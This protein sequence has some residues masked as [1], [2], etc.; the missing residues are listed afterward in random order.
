ML[1]LR[2]L[3]LLASLAAMSMAVA[4][5]GAQTSYS[6]RDIGTLGGTY[7]APYGVNNAGTVVGMSTLANG[8]QHGFYWT[9]ASGMADIGTLGGTSSDSSR[10]FAVNNLGDGAG[11]STVAAGGW[12]AVVWTASTGLTDLN[13]LLSPADAANWV[14][15]FGWNTNDNRQVI[16]T[17]NLSVNGTVS[18]H[19]YLLDITTGAITDLGV[20]QP[21]GINSLA[22]PQVVGG[23][24][25]TAYFYSGG[26]VSSLSPL[27]NAY[28]INNAGQ[29]AGYL[30]SGHPTVRS[31]T[32][33]ILDLGTFG[34]PGGA[35]YA[36]NNASPAIIVGE[37]DAQ[38]G[39]TVTKRAFRY[40]SGSSAKQDLNSLTANLGKW[41]LIDTRSVSDNGYIA[42]WADTAGHETGSTR[43]YLLT[44]K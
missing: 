7:A 26:V 28:G 27:V 11:H 32:G 34:G 9:A 19:G 25:G 24:S 43:A 41:I 12:H 33:S 38:K 20:W 1:R 10:L 3:S 21:R 39:S 36:V 5:A 42:S 17:G 29:V 35:A 8:A 31:A 14:L 4:G 23:A 15:V 30:S 6:F 13:T 16:G 2:N 22:S 37:A 44:P 18:Q 40:L